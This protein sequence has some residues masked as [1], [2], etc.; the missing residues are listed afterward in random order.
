MIPF[1]KPESEI[2]NSRRDK[3]AQHD[4]AAPQIDFGELQHHKIQRALLVFREAWRFSKLFGFAQFQLKSFD[5]L[6]HIQLEQCGVGTCEATDIYGRD[7]DVEVTFLERA[8]VIAADLRD[9]GD[10]VD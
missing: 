7:K 9:L 3:D 1:R 10:L 4:A 2:N 6:R 5:D 8:N